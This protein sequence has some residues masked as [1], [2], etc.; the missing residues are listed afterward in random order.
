MQKYMSCPAN[1]DQHKLASA[2]KRPLSE[3]GEGAGLSN[4]YASRLQFRIPSLTGF[5][6]YWI[7]PDPIRLLRTLTRRDPSNPRSRKAIKSF[8]M[9]FFDE[10]SEGS[11]RWPAAQNLCASQ[12][13]SEKEVLL[14]APT[15]LRTTSQSNVP[16]QSAAQSPLLIERRDGGKAG[17][18]EYCVLH[19]SAVA[20]RRV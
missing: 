2:R 7:A 17:P 10:N 1:T 6:A 9:A 3:V 4:F 11:V 5:R 12:A 16:T 15:A 14:R 13:P 20:P 8:K 19:L 18:G